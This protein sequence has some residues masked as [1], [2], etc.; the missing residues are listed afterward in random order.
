MYDAIVEE[1]PELPAGVQMADVVRDSHRTDLQAAAA[2]G[3]VTC[4]QVRRSPSSLFASQ[5]LEMMIKSNQ[6]LHGP[7]TPTV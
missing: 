5:M 4:D 1:A 6:D 2:A 7:S 3:T